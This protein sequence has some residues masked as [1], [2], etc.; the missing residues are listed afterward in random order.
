[1]KN[2]TEKPFLPFE[3]ATFE[4]IDE[5]VLKWIK[6]Q[7]IHSSFVDG[8]RPVPVIWAT[9]ERAFQVKNLPE[10]RD[11]SGRM[12]FPVI[13]VARTGMDKSLGKKGAFFG[14]IPPSNLNDGRGGSINVVRRIEQNK[15]Q[16]FANRKAV[17]RNSQI[18]FRLKPENKKVVYEHISLSMPVHYEATYNIYIDTDYE[19]QMNEI[20]QPF[21]VYAGNINYFVLKNK[22]HKFD[23]FID[24]S[25]NR[26]TNQDDLGTEP[27]KFRTIIPLRVLG[28]VQGNDKNQTQPKKVIRENPVEIVF[29][30]ERETFPDNK[31]SYRTRYAVISGTN[32]S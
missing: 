25:F 28:Y 18:T 11:L 14:N 32:N 12:V 15:T 19:T 7:N 13:S 31:T 20:V 26:E 6:E 30:P 10:L 8:F 5:A 17:N 1:M 21:M 9:Q 2:N 24:G 23:A 16:N 29:P 3:P 4:T 27:R 22:G